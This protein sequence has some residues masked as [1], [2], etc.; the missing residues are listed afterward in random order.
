MVYSGTVISV[1]DINLARK[2]YEELF[3]LE[4]FQDYG[5]NIS[6][7]CGLSLQQEFDWL[8]GVPRERILKESNNFELYF[9]EQDFDSFLKKLEK[10]PNIIY[11]S[12]VK[13][14]SWG[15]RTIRFYDLDGHLIEVGEEKKMVAKRFLSS[16]MSI[17][18]T[19]KCMDVS[20]S[21]LKKLLNASKR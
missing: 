11:L 21:D 13:E 8:I 18:E 4:V 5:I 16:G 14:Q 3:G 2:F 20:V 15:Q 9:E 10:F 6:F 7:S 19:S 17:E 12:E 1:G